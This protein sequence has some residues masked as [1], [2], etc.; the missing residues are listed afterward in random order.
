MDNVDEGSV[1]CEET[2]YT[3]YAD[4]TRNEWTTKIQPALKK[5]PLHVLVKT[6]EERLSRRELIDLRASRRKPHRKTKELLVSNLKKL[7]FM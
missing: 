5:P 2:V 4:P 6:C 7:G 3:E 1:H